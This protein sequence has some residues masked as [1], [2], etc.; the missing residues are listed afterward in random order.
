LINETIMANAQTAPQPESESRKQDIEAAFFQLRGQWTEDTIMSSNLVATI[1][2]P[3]YYS[4][5]GLG[6]AALPLI[7][8]DLKNGGGPWFV[9]LQAI[10]RENLASPEN[11]TDARKLRDDW[12]AWGRA[13]GYLSA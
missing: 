2:H 6:R 11:A 4:I 7:L 13:H 1:T 12:L 10:T 3:A 9:A 5:I 8:D